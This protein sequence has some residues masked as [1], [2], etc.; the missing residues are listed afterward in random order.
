MLTMRETV[1]DHS[2]QPRWSGWLFNKLSPT[3]LRDLES[4]EIPCAYPAGVTLF[5]ERNQVPGIFVILTGEV[6]L[7]MSSY[8]G[9]RLALQIARPNDVIGV[10]SAVSGHPAEWTAETLFPAT[11]ALIERRKFLAF[12][13]RHPEVFQI[14]TEELSRGMTMA[15]K[16]MRTLGLT[17]SAREKLA[18]LL[19]AWGEN[20][21]K[22]GGETR[23]QLPLTHGEIGEFIGTSRETVTRIMAHFKHRHLV[24]CRG[25]TLIIPCRMALES[26]ARH[27]RGP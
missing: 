8:G 23:F 21:R 14:L 24:V 5:S 11:I 10:V 13:T 18:R 17:S 25:A 9:R 6:K 20:G 4:M 27:R 19:L 22:T 16:Q 15:C 12:L 3:A 7:S 2:R 26:Y 1:S